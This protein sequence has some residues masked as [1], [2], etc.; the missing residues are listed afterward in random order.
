MI[1]LNVL[2][3]SHTHLSNV[4]YYIILEKLH[5]TLGTYNTYGIQSSTPYEITLHDISTCKEVVVHMVKLFNKHQLSPTH[6][7]DVV[8]DMI[9]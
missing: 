7:K 9:S 2:N 8:S 6:I 5:S 1:N 4:N 3:N